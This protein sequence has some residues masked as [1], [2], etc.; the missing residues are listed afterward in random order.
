MALTP[1]QKTPELYS[2]FDMALTR[3]PVT[4]DV[5]RKTND[6][7][8]KDS[9]KNIVLTNHGERPFQPEF[10]GN[11]RAQLFE[12]HTPTTYKTIE[13][14]IRN[15]LERF[16]PRIELLGVQIGGK[17]D[18]DSNELRAYI[19]YIPINNEEATTLEILLERVR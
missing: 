9:I 1:L 17:N 12:T 16:E 5:S 7:A 6:N 11:I 19:E 15:S 18:L 4:N 13:T 14:Q 8:I 10:G 3:H 2:D